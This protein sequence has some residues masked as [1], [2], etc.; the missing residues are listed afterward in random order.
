VT[1]NRCIRLQNRLSQRKHR[2][3]PHWHPRLHEAQLI[4][5][6]ETGQR[7]KTG[8]QTAEAAG[9]SQTDSDTQELQRGHGHPED[10]MDIPSRLVSADSRSTMQY[11][12]TENDHAHDPLWLPV[13]PII[14]MP[15]LVGNE[16]RVS[17]PG[18]T[19]ATCAC[20]SRVA[21]PGHLAFHHDYSSAESALPRRQSQYKLSTSR[22]VSE[23]YT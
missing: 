14:T 12:V 9:G 16:G 13:H 1:N 19:S 20:C 7:V 8:S 10:T 5:E 2:M 6:I 3:Q 23:E 11:P 4:E 21:A 17:H 22:C 15:T 18:S